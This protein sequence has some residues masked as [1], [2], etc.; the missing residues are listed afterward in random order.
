MHD[1]K[2]QP[3]PSDSG[4]SLRDMIPEW[5]GFAASFCC[6]AKSLLVFLKQKTFKGTKTPIGTRPSLS[7]ASAC[8]RDPAKMLQAGP[9]PRG[10]RLESRIRRSFEPVL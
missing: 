6:H 10:Q 1:R 3:C 8:R 5:C 7:S 4:G 9:G 2:I